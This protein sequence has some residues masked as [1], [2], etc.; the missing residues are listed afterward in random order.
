[1][2]LAVKRSKILPFGKPMPDAE[3]TVVAKELARVIEFAHTRCLES[4]LVMSNSARELWETSYKGWLT[5]DYPGI[6]GAVTARAEAQALRLAMVYAQLDGAEKLIEL[7][8]LEAAL[9][10]WRYCLDSAAYI[11]G[12]AEV[13]PI[14]QRIIEA[15]RLGPKT[16]TQLS[17]LF[18]GNVASAR[19]K[20]ALE[21]LSARG[22]IVMAAI[23]TSGAPAT[24]W[25]LAGG[26]N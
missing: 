24:V 2:W 16:Q 6:L 18:S 13:D 23:E 9:A 19:I 26:T 17:K 8:H 25:S 21:S 5:A 14:A 15:L 11:F 20:Q 7:D 3:V 1:M 12:D 10:F 22:R 4:E